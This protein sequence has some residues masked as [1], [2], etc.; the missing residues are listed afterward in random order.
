[1]AGQ[2]GF[3]HR[4]DVDQLL[5][6]DDHGEG[7]QGHGAAGVTGAASARDDGQAQLDAALHQGAD[8]LFGI[9]IE[10]DEGVFDAPV[11]GVRHMG[12]PGQAIEGHVV[13]A[14]V[15]GESLERLL[16]QHQ[17]VDKALLEAVHGLVGGFHQLGHLA[18]ALRVF[19]GGFAAALFHFRQAMAQGLYQGVTTAGRGQQ[20]VFQVGVALHHPD[21]SQHLVEHAGGTAGDPFGAEFV[22]H[23]PHVFAQQADD[24]LPV[25]EGG[26]VVGDFAQTCSHRKGAA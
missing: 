1:V 18:A 20:V 14:G 22:Q 9:G 2:H 15:T 24:D 13:L 16:A 4:A 25:G 17:G 12:D 7:R 19:A 3:F 10:D 11:G 23:A 21:V 6:V 8:F 26:V 5:G